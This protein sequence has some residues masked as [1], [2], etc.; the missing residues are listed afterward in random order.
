MPQMQGSLA[1]VGLP[2]L[3][4]FLSGLQSTGRLSVQQHLWSGEVWLDRGQIV[5]AVVGADRGRPALEALAL[6]CPDGRFT[7]DEAPLPA[8]RDVDGPTEPL[9]ADLEATVER[10]AAAGQALA[11][12]LAAHWT[13]VPPEQDDEAGA[14]GA[15]ADTVVIDGVALQTLLAVNNGRRTIEELAVGRSLIDTIE[16]LQR[17]RALGLVRPERPVGPAEPEAAGGPDG[18][19][20]GESLRKSLASEVGVAGDFRRLTS[21]RGTRSAARP[22]PQPPEARAPVE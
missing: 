21:D 17:L 9:L 11:P 7:F 19:A 18:S 22:T 4:R 20:G 12:V 1:G 13:V 6:V 15:P 5:A 8:T 3:V 10:H 16:A 2:A 14:P